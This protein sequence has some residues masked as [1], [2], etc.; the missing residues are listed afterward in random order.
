VPNSEKPK[1]VIRGGCPDGFWA[2]SNCD[3]AAQLGLCSVV[4]RVDNRVVTTDGGIT[5]VTRPSLSS[6]GAE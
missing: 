1:V 5:T 6:G 4:T 3:R 2:L